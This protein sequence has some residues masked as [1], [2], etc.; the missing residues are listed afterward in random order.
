MSQRSQGLPARMRR[1]HRRRWLRMG[2]T[3]QSIHLLKC[4]SVDLPKLEIS[5]LGDEFNLES[6]LFLEDADS[7]ES[8]SSSMVISETTIY[9]LTKV[10]ESISNQ[11]SIYLRN[12][13]EAKGTR[14][15]NHSAS[16]W[17]SPNHTIANCIHG[18][19]VHSLPS[20]TIMLLCISIQRS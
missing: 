3:D 14:K 17:Q 15:S 11:T 7:G 8:R 6:F 9:T 16:K 20:F 5:D 12:A 19:Q 18:L 4:F 10:E 13:F 1:G 2:W